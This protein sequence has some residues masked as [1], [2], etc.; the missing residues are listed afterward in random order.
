MATTT[1]RRF[2]VQSAEER[3][4]GQVVE[5]LS[6]EDAALSFAEHHPALLAGEPELALDVE[7]L[8]TGERQCLCVD[9]ATGEAEPCDAE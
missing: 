2:C 8:E 7:D 5:G 3:G 9:R 4:H 1:T 6:F